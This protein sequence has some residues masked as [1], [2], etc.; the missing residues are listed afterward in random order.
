VTPLVAAPNTHRVLVEGDADAA[1]RGLQ[2][3]FAI[4]THDENLA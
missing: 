3:S 2:R 1:G 4:T